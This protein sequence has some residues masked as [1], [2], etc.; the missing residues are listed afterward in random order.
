MC[1]TSVSPNPVLPAPPPPRDSA[2]RKWSPAPLHAP[3]GTERNR[4]QR[5]V[6][7]RTNNDLR[8]DLQMLIGFRDRKHGVWWEPRI[9]RNPTCP[10]SAL[11][12]SNG[13]EHSAHHLGGELDLVIVSLVYTV[14]FAGEKNVLNLLIHDHNCLIIYPRRTALALLMAQMRPQAG[15]QAQ[16]LFGVQGSR[17]VAPGPQATLV[18]VR[19]TTATSPS[20]YRRPAGPRL[21]P[22]RTRGL[23][24]GTIRGH[25]ES[26]CPL[27]QRGPADLHRAPGS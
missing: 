13:E 24:L 20:W 7:E 2:P 14:Q 27:A 5:A 11:P 25:W 8:T 23:G 15:H 10:R 6:R 3:V 9:L 21:R 1:S 17:R 12:V 18:S 22:A 26:P 19:V 16:L 4:P